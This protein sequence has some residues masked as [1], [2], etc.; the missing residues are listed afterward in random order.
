[1]AFM[2]LLL[3]ENLINGYNT[4]TF[5]SIQERRICYEYA[6]LSEILRI[7]TWGTT[8]KIGSS[9]RISIFLIK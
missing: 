9:L 4:C 6:M 5:K 8:E 2:F 1:M 3:E 7:P